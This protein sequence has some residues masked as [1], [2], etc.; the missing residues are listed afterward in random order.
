M[1]LLQ[2]VMLVHL[3]LSGLSC[4]GTVEIIEQE[5]WSN[6]FSG[7]ESVFHFTVTASEAFQGNAMWQLSVKGRTVARGESAVSADPAQSAGIAVSVNVPPVKDT[8]VVQGTIAVTVQADGSQEPAARKDKTIWIFA[9]N[10]FPERKDWLKELDIQLFDPEKKTAERLE[11]AGMPFSLVANVDALAEGKGLIIVG[12]GVSLKDYRSLSENMIKAAAAGRT[13]L[14]LSLAAG[15]LVVP[16]MGEVDLPQPSSI[17]F[18]RGDAIRKLDKRLD[19]RA[20]PPDGKL[21]SRSIKLTDERNI[22]NGEVAQSGGGWTWVD[23]NFESHGRLLVCGMDIIGKWDDTPAARYLLAA[24]LEE[25]D[26]DERISKTNRGE[27][28]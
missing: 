13:V 22:V 28:E 7:K 1:K 17:R 12:E 4:A 14:C 3:L 25:M 18:D 24:L 6:V 16:G 21:N 26:R 11:N 10:P 20:W 9:D 23:M 8:V 15:E 2:A 19:A 27:A 5:P